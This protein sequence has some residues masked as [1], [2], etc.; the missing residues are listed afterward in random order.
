[1]NFFTAN[2]DRAIVMTQYNIYGYAHSLRL[3][4]QDNTFYVAKSP[5]NLDETTGNF[6]AFA[7]G[8]NM[9]RMPT[10]EHY[11]DYFKSSYDDYLAMCKRLH[12][13]CDGSEEA[14]IQ[15]I[16]LN[17]IKQS[18]EMKSEVAA[19][20]MEAST[21]LKPLEKSNHWGKAVL[22]L[23]EAFELKLNPVAA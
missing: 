3:F 21:F 9:G 4:F 18:E 10:D 7:A 2:I 20:K 13:D 5:K 11:V 23:A 1:M 22:A 8:F 15:F 14:A 17:I 12:K 16:I 19:G 6:M